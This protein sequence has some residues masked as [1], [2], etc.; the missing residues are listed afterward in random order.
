MKLLTRG[1]ANSG[2]SCPMLL[3]HCGRATHSQS[4]LISHGW[5]EKKAHDAAAVN[6]SNTTKPNPKIQPPPPPRQAWISP[7]ASSIF[8]ITTAAGVHACLPLP[9]PLPHHPHRCACWHC[10]ANCIALHLHLHESTVH[11]RHP[12]WLRHRTQATV[13]ECSSSSFAFWFLSEPMLIIHLYGWV[14]VNM[15]LYHV[16]GLGL[17]MVFSVMVPLERCWRGILH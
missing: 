14:I 5:S 10:V 2:H 12:R 1:V 6:I 4:H 11:N 3:C 8:L 16:K 7:A 17:S 13:G 15:S 9:L